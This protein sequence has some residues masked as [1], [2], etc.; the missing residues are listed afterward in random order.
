MLDMAYQRDNTHR[1]SSFVLNKLSRSKVKHFAENSKEQGRTRKL[2]VNH[3]RQHAV[4]ELP[5]KRSNPESSTS[6][7]H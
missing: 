3:R 4:R 6:Q 2:F 5:E 7:S 1:H